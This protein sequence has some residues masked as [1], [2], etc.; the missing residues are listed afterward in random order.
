MTFGEAMRRC[1]KEKGFSI[2]K[3]AKFS[4]ISF[5]MIC[6]IEEDKKNPSLITMEAL[7]ETLGVSLDEYVG[8]QEIKGVKNETKRS[9]AAD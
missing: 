3:L 8:W 6:Y 5:T 4:G 7:A 2:E 1:R 9:Q